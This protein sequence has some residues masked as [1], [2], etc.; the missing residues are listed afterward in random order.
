MN[1]KQ[2]L[3]A[4][5]SADPLPENFIEQVA[6]ELYKIENNGSLSE[7]RNNLNYLFNNPKQAAKWLKYY[8]EHAEGD[9]PL[10]ELCL[11]IALPADERIKMPNLWLLGEGNLQFLFKNIKQ[12]HIFTQY[13]HQ[14]IQP[15]Q[16][17]SLKSRSI[18]ND[19]ASF[20]KN[21]WAK[22]VALGDLSPLEKKQI[23]NIE[24]INK[25]FCLPPEDCLIEIMTLLRQG[26][27]SDEHLPPLIL[28]SEE[29][30][31]APGH[32]LKKL[33]TQDERAAMLG[34]FLECCQR[35]GKTGEDCVRQAISS[36]FGGT[37]VLFKAKLEVTGQTKINEEHDVP[38]AGSWVWADYDE[39]EQEVVGLCFDS[40]DSAPT[41]LDLDR[42][43]CEY[44]A[45]LLALCKPYGFR[46]STH[47]CAPPIRRLLFDAF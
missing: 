17:S 6:L 19:I 11:H 15:D 18:R 21:P 16:Y 43:F 22:Y 12:L 2:T 36:E 8:A 1:A 27:N 31:L 5:C 35:V 40:I 20:M 44:S 34:H 32:Y 14:M 13:H 46:R 24:R 23:E 29:I 37:Y 4:L 41:P 28:R 25:R 38:V 26:K 9:Q 7:H 45:R 39:N 3:I 47:S 33:E 30:G 42:F 10:Y